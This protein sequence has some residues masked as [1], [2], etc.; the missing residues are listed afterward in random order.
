[1]LLVAADTSHNEP[2]CIVD[3]QGGV[4]LHNRDIFCVFD[5]TMV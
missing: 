2:H 1:M 5:E 3:R 4:V